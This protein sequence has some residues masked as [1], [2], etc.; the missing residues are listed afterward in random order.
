MKLL[1]AIAVGLRPKDLEHAPT[2]RSI[3]E[4]GFVAPLTPVFPAVTCPV[5]ATFLTGTLP[6]DHG[7][8]ANG[9]YHRTTAEVRFWL[10]SNHLIEGEKV[11]ESLA[12]DAGFSC[13]KLFWWFNMYSAAAISVTPRPEYHSDGLKQPGLYSEPPRLKVDLQRDL[14]DFPLF[15]FWGP[16]AGIASTEWIAASARKVMVQ[17]D[18]TLTLVYLPHLDYDHQRYGPDDPRSQAAVGALDSAMA[19]LLETARE[20]GREVLVLSEYG[21]EPVDRPVFLNRFLRERGWLAVG[22]TGHGELLDAGR[23]KAFAVCD[24]QAAHVYVRDPHDRAAVFALLSALEGVEQ[25][26]D[27]AAQRDFGIDHP[28]AGEFVC[29][30]EPGAW[31]AYPYWLE[32]GKR[33]D[34]ATSVDIHRKPGYDPAELFLDPTL[35][36]PK[37]RIARRLLQK[38]LGF[39]YRMDVIPTD[40]S[41]VRGSHGR[42]PSDPSLGAVALGSFR[43]E[44][45]APLPAVEVSALIQSRLR[46]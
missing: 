15:Q 30:A 32:E 23:S 4:E 8:V 20:T 6:R 11:Y 39:R 36:A 35:R 43:R 34:F 27:R 31:F 33:P 41:M 40:P 1:V 21:I 10:Q 14:G 5:Q 45:E 12:E 44:S 28:R 3:A 19:P 2:L 37:A 24:H 9:W 29:L 7:I 38:K 16:G 42:L 26:L 18:P 13:A 17:D 46:G 25:V 22:E